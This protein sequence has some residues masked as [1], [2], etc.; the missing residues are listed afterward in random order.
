MDS[1]RPDE[2][3]RVVRRCPE[4]LEHHLRWELRT[5]PALLLGDQLEVG[6]VQIGTPVRDTRDRLLPGY[7][8]QFCVCRDGGL[9][10]AETGVA[11]LDRA[12][13]EAREWH[14]G[15]AGAGRMTAHPIPSRK[16]CC[17]W[18]PHSEQVPNPQYSLAWSDG[19]SNRGNGMPSSANVLDTRLILMSEDRGVQTHAPQGRREVGTPEEGS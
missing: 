14:R 1:S 13:S 11:C 16:Q 15:L 7:H 12:A 8:A 17:D 9:A 6:A 19:P 4:Q 18:P 3:Y 10:G 5:D 2:S